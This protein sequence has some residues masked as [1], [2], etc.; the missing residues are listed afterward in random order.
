MTLARTVPALVGCCW[1]WSTRAAGRLQG[2]SYNGA[3]RKRGPHCVV[4]PRKSVGAQPLFLA[5]DFV[6]SSDGSGPRAR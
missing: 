2:K 5:G 1:W 6:D 3:A 4:V